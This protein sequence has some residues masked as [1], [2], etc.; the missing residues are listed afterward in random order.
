MQF[1]KAFFVTLFCQPDRMKGCKPLTEEERLA[2]W[3]RRRGEHL[4]QERLRQARVHR[5]FDA[6]ATV[7]RRIKPRLPA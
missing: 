5:D 6:R 4:A 1:V 3:E 2:E 7:Q